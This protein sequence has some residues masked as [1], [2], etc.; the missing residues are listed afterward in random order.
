MLGSLAHGYPWWS[1]SVKTV[2]VDL[3]LEVIQY[4]TRDM[5]VISTDVMLN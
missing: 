5:S 4:A 2:L 3:E 1:T